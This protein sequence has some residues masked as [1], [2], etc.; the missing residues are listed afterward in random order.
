[1][2]ICGNLCV[3][4]GMQSFVRWDHGLEGWIIM[5]VFNTAFIIEPEKAEVMRTRFIYFASLKDT[6]LD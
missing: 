2:E 4:L 5:A 3:S 1:M 6:L